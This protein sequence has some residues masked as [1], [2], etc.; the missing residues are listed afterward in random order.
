ME[1]HRPLQHLVFGFTAVALFLLQ[2]QLLSATK[3]LETQKYLNAPPA[4]LE[5]F[6]FG[7]RL[8]LADSLWIRWIQDSDYCQTYG[9]AP[10]Q[11]PEN[12]EAEEAFPQAEDTLTYNVRHRVCDGSWGYQMLDA[13]SR[14]DPKFDMVYQGGAIVL[15]VLVEDFE[16]ASKLF[17]R[18]L[19]EYPND[20]RLAYL[21]AY[22]FLYDVRDFSRAAELLNKAGD[23]GAP[24]WVK[25]LASRLYSRSGQLELGI[26]TL[27]GYK[28]LVTDAGAKAKIQSRINDLKRQLNQQKGP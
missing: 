2:T 25:S 10:V 6:A 22:H 11:L 18:G 27:E 12:K 26:S 15:S 17:E 3:T 4:Y 5:R 1:A 28:K 21:A 13:V 24:I 23:L 7:F 8:S 20:W 19:K 16:G 9:E 14:L